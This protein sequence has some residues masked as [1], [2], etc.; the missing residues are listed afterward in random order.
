MTDALVFI[1]MTVLTN[2]ADTST[3]LVCI[4]TQEFLSQN[5]NNLLVSATFPSR[6][7]NS[8]KQEYSWLRFHTKR[9][10]FTNSRIPGFFT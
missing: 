7:N 1:T 6:S 3:Y 8:E 5:L 10:S 4:D 9:D 2:Y